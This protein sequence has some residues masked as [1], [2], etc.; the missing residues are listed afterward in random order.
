MCIQYTQ[1]IWDLYGV[2]EYFVFLVQHFACCLLTL[3]VPYG[4]RFIIIWFSSHLVS[5]LWFSRQFLC[6]YASVVCVCIV[7][8]SVLFIP[9]FVNLNKLMSLLFLRTVLDA[10]ENSLSPF[11][12]L[13]YLIELIISA[14][15]TCSGS[16]AISQPRYSYSACTTISWMSH[17]HLVSLGA[18]WLK[19]QYFVAC[20]SICI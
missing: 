20:L 16:L 5:I 8:V 2:N 10:L 17:S 1:S 15:D 4:Q 13:S 12:Q 19:F 14:R 3:C 6:V 9:A 7:S 11:F 18:L